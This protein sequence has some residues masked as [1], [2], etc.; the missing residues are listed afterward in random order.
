MDDGDGPD[1]AAAFY[2]HMFDK[3]GRPVDFKGAAKG[4]YRIATALRKKNVP[5]QRWI[6]F[7][8][9]GASSLINSGHFFYASIHGHSI[10]VVVAILPSTSYCLIES[11]LE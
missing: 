4:V 6:N 8:H 9:F 10:T 11:V 1:V 5:L 3:E 2:Q 7:V